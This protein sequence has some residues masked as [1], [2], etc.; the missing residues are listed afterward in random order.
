MLL[1]S[2]ND[3]MSNFSEEY[4]V[5]R[6]NRN[7]D[8]PCD[9]SIYPS[10]L[11][12]DAPRQAAVLV[13][14][15]RVKKLPNDIPGWRW[16]VLYTRRTSSLAEHSG[17]VAFPGGRSDPD[18]PSPEATVLREAYEE[19]GLNPEDVRILGRL[20]HL[21]T[22]TNY[23]IT[24]VVGVMPWPYPI[25]LETDE[26]S[27]VFTIPLEWLADTQNHEVRHRPLPPPFSG[28]PVIY[29]KAYEGELLWGVSASITV[30]LLETLLK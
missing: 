24:P 12:P 5:K 22:I 4:I 16:H 23:C 2:V 6:L 26:V 14:L 29:F 11:L 25:S 3:A 21:L 18:D 10:A 15:V 8:L 1:F 17:Q 28:V 7:Q 27:R 9:E 30:S 13:P 20:E 19:I